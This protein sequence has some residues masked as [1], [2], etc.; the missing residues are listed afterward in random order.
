MRLDHSHGEIDDG[1][2]AQSCGNLQLAIAPTNGQELAA[3]T[4]DQEEEDAKNRC[5]L[6]ELS[7]QK[8]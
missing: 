1:V 5:R 7:D 8:P 4:N 3:A 6:Q 2:H